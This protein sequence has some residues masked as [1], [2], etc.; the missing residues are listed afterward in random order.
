MREWRE[1]HSQLLALIG[2]QGWRE[3]EIPATF[4]AIHKA[5]LTG[6]LGNVVHSL[7][8]LMRRHLQE[9]PETDVLMLP[10][11]AQAGQFPVQ[12]TRVHG[13]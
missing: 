7:H 2:E 1:T 10:F 13:V 11:A 3:N 4:E 5:L 6:L 9:R 8:E 12:L